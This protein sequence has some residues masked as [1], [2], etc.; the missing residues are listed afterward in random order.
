LTWIAIF[1]PSRALRQYF[2]AERLFPTCKWGHLEKS[3]NPVA[4]R[5]ADKEPQ[6]RRVPEGW[7]GAPGFSFDA[8]TGLRAGRQA[9][10]QVHPSPNARA[11]T[12]FGGLFGRQIFF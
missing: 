1:E 4:V 10:L 12:L 2:E 11:K 6:P 7:I 5:E 9:E 8:T 3:D